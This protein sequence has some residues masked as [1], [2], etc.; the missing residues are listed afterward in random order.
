MRGKG[1]GSR[2]ARSPLAG[3]ALRES[4]EGVDAGTERGIAVAAA[5]IGAGCR[6]TLKFASPLSK[7]TSLGPFP[8]IL[9]STATVRESDEA[10]FGLGPPGA[11]GSRNL[12]AVGSSVLPFVVCLI[13]TDQPSSRRNARTA[14]YTF[15]VFSSLDG[16]GAA[17][18][19]GTGYWG[20]QG[21][22]LLDRRPARYAEEQRMV[23]LRSHGSRSMNR[24]L[25]AAPR[26]SPIGPTCT[27]EPCPRYG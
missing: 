17:G 10:G 15:D 26:S 14:T 1:E 2:S 24:A 7:K 9:N 4:A 16:F 3:L 6:T 11:F 20:K 27:P 25:M 8:A 23:P 18:G 5:R 21:P 22:E 19:D 12:I 13:T